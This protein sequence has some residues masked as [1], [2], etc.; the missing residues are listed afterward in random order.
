M[1]VPLYQVEDIIKQ[2][3]MPQLSDSLSTLISDGLIIFDKYAFALTSEK[4]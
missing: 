1:T 3:S 2:F 4:Y